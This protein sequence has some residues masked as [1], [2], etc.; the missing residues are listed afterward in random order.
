MKLLSGILFLLSFQLCAQTF[1]ATDE[2][3]LSFWGITNKEN[4]MRLS[5]A[6]FSS[7]L[8]F[9][10][11]ITQGLN[12]NGLHFEYA[13]LGI[14]GDT[15]QGVFRRIKETDIKKY[16]GVFIE[17]GT[18]NLLRAQSARD[19]SLEIVQLIKYSSENAKSVYIN[20]IFIPDIN[21]YPQIDSNF[22]LANKAIHNTCNKYKNCKVIRVPSEIVGASGIFENM[23]IDDK[24]HLNGK[25]YRIWKTELN[26]AMAPFPYGIFYRTFK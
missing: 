3:P 15:V 23:S 14:A 6:K 25:A 5:Q 19:L 22:S 12:N 10:D 16:K 26:K 21:M 9:G 7:I 4:Q 18:N 8:M 13:N 24:V 2:S 17:V 11:S 1:I 20:E